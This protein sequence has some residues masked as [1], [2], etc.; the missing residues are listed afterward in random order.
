VA[1]EA[2][3]TLPLVDF[4]RLALCTEHL[5]Y[6]GKGA[7]SLVEGIDR[8]HRGRQ[9]LQSNKLTRF[10]T[11]AIPTSVVI[12]TAKSNET[13]C[14]SQLGGSVGHHETPIS[15][16]LDEITGTFRLSSGSHTPIFLS[17]TNLAMRSTWKEINALTEQGDV[18][19]AR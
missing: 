7:A 6:S 9:G 12:Q 10:W 16:I 15:F 2:D 13:L 5:R 18:I 4:T 17:G 1:G 3:V 11:V 14:L 8:A 19:C